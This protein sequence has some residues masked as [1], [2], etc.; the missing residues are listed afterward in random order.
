LARFDAP[1]ERHR[2]ERLLFALYRTVRAPH[3]VVDVSGVWERRV[4]AVQAHAS[5]LD[6]ARG[7]ATYLTDPEF[8]AEVDARARAFGAAIGV[9]H[10]EGY[11]V[12]G[13]VA[14][15]DARALLS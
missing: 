12:R 9:R 8:E 3:L 11:R 2:P 1:G 14:L 13:P 5:Q 10:G 15:T 6:P 4:Q 7:S